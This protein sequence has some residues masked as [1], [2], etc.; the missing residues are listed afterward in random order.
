MT[1]AELFA[2]LHSLD[3]QLWAEGDRLRVSAPKGVLTPELSA[4][5]SSRKGAILA[6]LRAAQVTENAAAPI[7]PISRDQALPLSFAQQRIWFMEQMEPGNSAYNLPGILRLRGQLNAQ[8]L[9]ES[10]TA[11]IARHETLRTSPALVDGRPVQR[12]A[13]PY[14]FT[15]PTLDLRTLPLAERS[16]AA[17]QWCQEE[18]RRPFDLTQVPLFRLT[19]LR[20]DQNESL[21]ALT[22]HHSISDGWSLD[23]FTRELSRLYFAYT[24]GQPSPLTPLVVQYADFAYWQRQWL[25]SD[26]LRDQIAYWKKQLAGPLPLLNLPTDYARPAVQTYN[27][28]KV[29]A[30]VPGPR[31]R[32]L[33][34]LCQA[35]D[36]TLFMLLLA[37]FNG[38]LYRYTDQT[39]LLVGTP[40][41]GRTRPETEAIIGCFLNNLVLRTQ[42]DGDQPFRALLK[43]V[44]EVALAAYAHQDLPFEKLVEELQPARDVS[45]SP[46]FQ[47]MFLQNAPLAPIALQG[48]EILGPEQTDNAAAAFDLTLSVRDNGDHL[49]TLLEY[50]TDLFAPETMQRFLACY[51][52]L[53]AS[54]VANPDQS[55]AALPILAPEERQRLLVTWNET[56]AAYPH[57]LGIHTL[58]EAQAD[59]RPQAV[60]AVYGDEQI[61]YQALEQRAN[62]LAHTLAGLG[63]GPATRVGIFVERSLDMLVALLGTLKAG[64]TYLPLDPAFPRERLA[65]ML[66]DAQAPLVLTQARLLGELPP[67]AAQTL[68]LDAGHDLIDRA[69]HSRPALPL[70]P[71]ALAYLIYT[72]GSTGKP[73]GVQVRHQGVVN[74]LESMRRRPGMGEDDILAAV[75]TLSFDIAVL[76]L[77][78]P[79]IV[80]GRVVIVPREVAA[81]GPGLASVLAQS[82]A[83]MMQATPSTWR[84]LLDAGWT[85]G[86]GFKAL[87]GGEAFP[88]ELAKRLLDICGSVWNMYGPT[89]TTIWSTVHHVTRDDGSVPIGRPIANTQIYILDRHRGPVPTGVPGDLYIGG[90]GLALGYWQRPELTQERFVPN[91]F[92]STPLDDGTQPSSRI[93]QTGDQAR[94]RHDGVI[95]FLGRNDHQVKLRGFRI[96]LG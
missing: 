78:L 10:V 8:A 9:T 84:L 15:L 95:D 79:L 57:S 33:K 96:E 63:V 61:S 45:R 51:T 71:D 5:L 14:V 13:P 56:Q 80:G 26:A 22:M 4:E 31:T 58:F 2:Y 25:Q 16:A 69:P 74:F 24:Q 34:T 92:A 75:T 49:V 62:Q 1:L 18:A 64:A 86:A 20:L 85:G 36:V 28:A 67:S 43:Q 83:T 42:V 40:V 29:T 50:N 38:L 17:E 54:I 46:L 53:L 32:S 87:C 72:S 12:I 55:V 76:E 65:F 7:P 66:E 93:Y 89:E 27:G 35:E 30:T 88:W 48:L 44:R 6:A 47:V 3:V 19:L 70:A 82:G 73:K 91:P 60:A 90:D 52:T 81:D 23:L 11:L 77:M 94:Y 37:A 68:A 39:D 59:R 21:L 41:A